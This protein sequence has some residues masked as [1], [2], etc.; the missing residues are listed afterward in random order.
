MCRAPADSIIPLGRALVVS[1]V[2][3]SD[4]PASFCP[5]PE[6]QVTTALEDAGCACSDMSPWLLDW[7]SLFSSLSLAEASGLAP[8]EDDVTL[9]TPP[10]KAARSV[11]RRPLTTMDVDVTLGQ[12]RAHSGTMWSCGDILHQYTGKLGLVVRPRLIQD[13][14]HGLASG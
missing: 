11:R 8:E 7:R 4:R 14:R 1:F 5:P 13:L 6:W 10:K 2:W 9:V 12:H 3:S